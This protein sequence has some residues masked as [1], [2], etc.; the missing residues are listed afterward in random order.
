MIQGINEVMDRIAEI[1]SRINGF[2]SMGQGPKEPALEGSGFK[3]MLD[4]NVRDISALI[5]SKA[6]KFSLDS[7][8]IRSVVKVES[9]GNATA[10]SSKGAKGLMQLMPKTAEDLGVKDVF[11]E[12]ENLE[13]GVKYLKGLIDKY[14]DLPTALAAY[15]AGPGEV[16][17]NNGIPNFKETKDY[18]NKVL[19]TY[20]SLKEKR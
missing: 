13:G 7:D 9:D 11:N 18:V 6:S 3:N 12:E 5:E 15:N 10:V 20:N 8:L 17:K 1:Q 16:D 4:S 2:C 14:K 19:E